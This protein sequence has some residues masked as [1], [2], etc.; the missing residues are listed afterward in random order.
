MLHKQREKKRGK[1]NPPHPHK[2][3]KKNLKKNGQKP[4]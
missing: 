2:K 4:K 3:N 1:E